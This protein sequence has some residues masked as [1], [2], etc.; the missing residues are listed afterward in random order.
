MK[1]ISAIFTVVE[2]FNMN[3]RLMILKLQG[4]KIGKNV[5]IYGKIKVVNPKKLIVGCNVTFNEG[6]YLNCKEEV[7]IDD[8][9]RLSAYSMLI[10]TQLENLGHSGKR[11]HISSPIFLGKNVWICAGAIIGMGVELNDGITVASNSFVNKSFDVKNSVVGGTPAKYLK[12][13]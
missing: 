4:A 3:F 11:G 6:V 10:S 5:K 8:N 9:C 2:F 12:N 13:V 1:F 7:F